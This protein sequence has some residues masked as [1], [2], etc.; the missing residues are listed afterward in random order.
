MVFI[1]YCAV[2]V[3]SVGLPFGRTLCSFRRIKR[4]IHIIRVRAHTCVCISTVDNN[5]REEFYSVRVWAAVSPSQC[6][7]IYINI[8][9]LRRCA[10]LINGVRLVQKP[11]WQKHR[12]R[13]WRSTVIVQYLYIYLYILT[14]N[15]N[16]AKQWKFLLFRMAIKLRDRSKYTWN[17][18][19]QRL[20]GKCPFK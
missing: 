9:V 11:P 20:G 16:Y 7:C 1:Y 13:R 19:R 2:V 14:I 10:L 5:K 18:R 3:V 12:N 17:A 6:I 8:N 4:I 15:Y